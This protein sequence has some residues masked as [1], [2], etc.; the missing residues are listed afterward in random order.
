M[1][2][3]ITLLEGE[4]IISDDSEVAEFMNNF[5]SNGVDKLNIQ[6]F[7]GKISDND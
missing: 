1:S 4:N 3:T 7:I 5:F 6:G 2:K